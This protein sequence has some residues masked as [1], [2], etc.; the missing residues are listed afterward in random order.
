MPENGGRCFE[1]LRFCQSGKWKVTPITQAHLNT[2]ERKKYQGDISL[3]QWAT[4]P[5]KTKHRVWAVFPLPLFPSSFI[6][7]PAFHGFAG[8]ACGRALVGADE[9]ASVWR[10]LEGGDG[11][12][13]EVYQLGHVVVVL[14]AVGE[15]LRV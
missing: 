1:D 13:V 6:F 4:C 7:N 12:T 3:Y 11:M 15:L 9:W 5:H 10:V 14:G 2:E 8:Y